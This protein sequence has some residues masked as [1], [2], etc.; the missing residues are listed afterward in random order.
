MNRTSGRSEANPR[1]L[2]AAVLIN[3]IGT[4]TSTLVLP[5]VAYQRLD[6]MSGGSYSHSARSSGACSGP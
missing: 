1:R 5:L 2:I 4:S 3:T 6:G